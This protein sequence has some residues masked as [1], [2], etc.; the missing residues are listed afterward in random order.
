MTEDLSWGPADESAAKTESTGATN[1]GAV[2]GTEGAETLVGQ[3]AI[4]VQAP[5]PD[6]VVTIP[7]VPGQRYVIDFDPA[8]A[9]IVVA[10]D[11]L[12]LTFAND[13]RI[14]FQ[15]IG[16]IDPALEAP[17]FEIAGADVPAS[18]L[19][20][21]AVALA[22]PAATVEGQPTLETAAGPGAGPGAQG[23]GA[24]QYS[25]DTGQTIDLLNPQGV[26]PGVERE[27]GLIT[28][29]NIDLLE[30]QEALLVV[31][32][33]GDPTVSI[34]GSGDGGFKED[35]PNNVAITAAVADSTDQ[36]TS[37]VVEGLT[38][39]IAPAELAALEAEADVAS[40]TFVGGTLTITFV[41]GVETFAYFALIMTP[42]EDTDVDLLGTITANAQDKTNPALTSS[43]AIGFTFV[44]DAV[45]DFQPEISQGSAPSVGESDVAQDISLG[46]SFSSVNAGFPLSGAGGPD[47]DGSESTTVEIEISAGTLQFDGSEPAGVS[48]AFNGGTGRWELTGYT[49]D[50][51]LGQAINALSINVP[52]GFD[53]DITGTIF[54]RT[55]EANTP[56]G[57][58]PGSGQEPE[59]SDNVREGTFEFS[60]TVRGDISQPTV[61]ISGSGDGGFKE[62]APNNVAISASVADSTDQ[63]TSIVVEG[64]TWGIAPAELTALEADADVASVTFVGGTLTITFVPGVESFTYSALTMTPPEDTDVDL[65]GTITANAQ[66]K[67]TPAL[68]SSTA[69]GFTFVVDAVLD[70]QPEIS[71][72]VAP[73]EAE[74][75]VAQDISLGLSFSTVNAGFPFSGA[76]GPDDDGS[77]STTVEIEISAGTLQFDGSEP[78]GVSL[79]F[80]GGTGRWELTGYANDA[81]LGQAINALSINVPA[82][83][84]G[85]ITGTVFTRTVE[86]NTPEGAAPGSGQEPETSDNVREGEFAFSATVEGSAGEPTVSI[87]GGGDGIFKEDT[88]GEVTFSAAVANSTDELTSL[89]ISGLTW[90]VAASELTDL[91]ALADVASATF[92]GDTLTITFVAGVESFNYSALTVT[93]PADT[94]V[95]LSGV[96]IT[97][98][99]QDKTTPALTASNSAETTFVVDAVLDFQPE[100]S[101]VLAPSVGESDVAQDIS[102]GLSFSTVNAGFPFSGAGGPDD[103][104]SE[105]TTVEIEISA[106]TLQFDG[107]EPA[108]VSLAFNGGTGRWELTGYANDAELGQAINALSINVP[109]GF[110]GVVTGTIFTR[111]AEANTPEGAAPGS[112][113]EPETSDN[114]REGAFEFSATVRGDI[115]VPEVSIV[116]NSTDAGA[117]F[118]EDLPHDVTLSASVSNS[119]DELTSLVVEGLTWGVSGGELSDLE[120]LADVASATFVGGT[121]T[122]TFVPGVE[123]FTYTELTMTPPEDTDVDLSGVVITAN[124]QDKTT[125]ALTASNSAG[126][127]FVVDAVADGGVLVDT[128]GIPVSDAGAP[129]S[130]GLTLTTAVGNPANPAGDA[131]NP[132]GFDT[133]GSESVTSVVVTLSGIGVADDSDAA[134][135]FDD[136][137]LVITAN[138]VAGSLVWEFLGSEADLQALMTTLQVDPSNAFEGTID[139]AVAVTT[140]EANTPQGAAPASGQEPETSDNTITETFN[141]SV[142]VTDTAPVAVDDTDGGP[143]V[144]NTNLIIVFDRSGSMGDNPS[145]VGFSDRINLA[146]AAIANLLHAVGPDGN[147][148]VM[149]VDFSSSA[150]TSGW[151]TTAVEANAYLGSLQFGGTTNYNAAINLAQTAFDVSMNPPTSGNNVTYFLSDGKPNPV[152]T[153]LDLG[154][155]TTWETFLAANNMPAFAIGIGGGVTTTELAPIAHDPNDPAG[156]ANTPILVTTEGEIIN[157]LVN[158]SGTAFNGNVLT[159]DLPGADGFGSP[160]ITQLALNGV[161]TTGFTSAFS[162][163]VA[164]VAGMITLTGSIGADDYWV[165]TLDTADAGAGNYQLT[166]LRP[167]PHT[168]DGGVGS[169]VFDYTIVDGDGD[170][171]SASLS[172]NINDVPGAG[173]GLPQIIDTANNNGVLNGTDADEILAGGA[174]NDILNAGGGNDHLYGGN[175]N[176][177]LNGG[178]GDDILIGGDGND[179]LNGGAGNDVLNGG[180][181]IDIL[182]GGADNDALYGGLGNDTLI[183]GLGDDLLIGGGGNDILDGGPGADIMHGSNSPGNGGSVDFRY[184]LADLGTG[185]DTIIGFDD[186]GSGEDQ[187]DLRDIFTGPENFATLIAGGFLILDNSAN[188]GGGPGNDTVVSID[189]DGAVG[190]GAPVILVNILDVNTLDSPLDSFNFIVN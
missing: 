134:L 3:A 121:L 9:Q 165:L 26:I 182:D 96:V 27:F 68:T 179:E 10:G 29:E 71:Q 103:D 114:V 95:D 78:A 166:L 21:Q 53:G 141:F 25:D 111:T 159:N 76:G 108:G 18:V 81:E 143:E 162:V 190:I 94:D 189:L 98:N 49:N 138:H 54:T 52:A 88:S 107:S 58:A 170:I 181:G 69:V 67:T 50:A 188:V 158:I 86:A 127:T 92:V 19:Y 60:A 8:A 59:T 180:A 44:V 82:G 20:Q 125:P 4:L 42:P 24:T 14:V 145:T 112:G 80:N 102:L 152:A 157:L 1:N 55:A 83:F 34:S 110:D 150:S 183:G 137:G 40:V 97:A 169:L 6:T 167:L 175:G 15:D 65:L 136:T 13:G 155:Q 17:I 163:A 37:I 2:S 104:G 116:V 151:L 147:V 172:F 174:G 70:F 33:V 178:D 100:V 5:P 126:T 122:I 99:V 43:T 56:E 101:Q 45:L 11:D 12:I 132:G 36:L 35:A 72:A 168:V 176:D 74:S 118:K 28:L 39:G 128:S 62:D 84:D 124:A 106:G 93:P 47:D 123:S 89:E 149:I 22:G 120:A 23:T 38:W 85:V 187:L 130:L 140:T 148:N 31:G 186:D 66:D 91:E 113:Q 105:S 77:E 173:V 75:D 139:V 73:T 90:G 63:L 160:A 164:S 161:A 185:V 109:A 41:P 64:L 146:R 119:T 142:T 115:G 79:A 61:A 144:G 7:V 171:D 30:E 46:L 16:A 87:S 117:Y 184:S 48:L 129:V 177:I 131:Q 154:E 32:S 153:G 135:L 156:A 51:E 133:D 57:A